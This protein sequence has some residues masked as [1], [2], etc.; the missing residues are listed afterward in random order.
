[1]GVGN[2][3]NNVFQKWHGKEPASRTTM[4]ST[5]RRQ[6][7][8]WWIPQTGLRFFDMRISH[9]TFVSSAHPTG[10]LRNAQGELPD[11]VEAPEG[12]EQ[13]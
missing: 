13:L 10:E 8:A 4:K 12:F 3:F 11:G 2:V 9:R 6:A 1:M 7:P 5:D